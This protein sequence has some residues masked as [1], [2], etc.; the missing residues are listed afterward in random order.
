MTPFI[1]FW[2][3][4][5]PVHRDVQI[6]TRSGRVAQPSPVDK[7]FVGIDAKDEIQREDDDILRQLR[8]LRPAF[9]FGSYW[10]HPTHI[11]I[12]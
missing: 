8:T 4:Y 5:G 12:H 2:E 10:H 6:I 9:P 7:P 11:E 3:E 1:L